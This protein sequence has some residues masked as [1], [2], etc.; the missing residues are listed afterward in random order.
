MAVGIEGRGSIAVSIEVAECASLLEGGSWSVVLLSAEVIIVSVSLGS[1]VLPS[2]LG[3]V[4]Y[5]CEAIVELVLIQGHRL[6]VKVPTLFCVPFVFFDN[7]ICSGGFI[8]AFCFSVTFFAV[9]S[10]LG[11][12]LDPKIVLNIRASLFS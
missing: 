12:V 11:L 6:S 5:Y 1:V 9:V 8:I 2:A 4:G 7:V 10:V 3:L